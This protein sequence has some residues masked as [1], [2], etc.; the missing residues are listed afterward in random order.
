MRV[1]GD[2]LAAAPV[3]NVTRGGSTTPNITM[4]STAVA[5]GGDEAAIGDEVSKIHVEVAVRNTT[6]RTFVF[7]KRDVSLRVERNGEEYEVLE[8]TG[9]GFEMTPD[10]KM[11]AKFDLPIIHNGSYEWAARTWFYE[12]T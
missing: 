11:L 10:S 2:N 8:T 6:N 9:D 5:P 3:R 4:V 1:S 12:K 7:A